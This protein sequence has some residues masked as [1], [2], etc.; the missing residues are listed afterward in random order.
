MV[1][2]EKAW[3]EVADEG[4]ALVLTGPDPVTTSADEPASFLASTTEF[5]R[6]CRGELDWREG[7]AWDARTLEV[8]LAAETSAREGRRVEV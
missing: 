5:L 7:F 3:C 1:M 6:A 2:G 4:K 8:S